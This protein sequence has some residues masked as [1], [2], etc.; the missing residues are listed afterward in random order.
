FNDLP[1]YDIALLKLSGEVDHVSPIALYTGSNEV[2]KTVTLLGW[3]DYG[4][5]DRG[6]AREQA[7]NDGLF[8]QATN[9]IIRAE[10]NQ[11]FFDFDPPESGASLPLEGVNGPGDSGGPALVESNEGYEII[12][13]SSG[14]YYPKGVKHDSQ[15]GRYGWREYYVRVSAMMEWIQEVIGTSGK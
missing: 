8:R 11:L 5:G 7:I 14:G 10:G 2:G 9:Q 6:I 12:G 15:E 3:G 1:A 13:I 4:T